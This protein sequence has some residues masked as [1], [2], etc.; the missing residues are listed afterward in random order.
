M[1]DMIVGAL[2]LAFFAMF[3]GGI[4]YDSNREREIAH[5]AFKVCIEAGHS[6][7]ECSA[8]LD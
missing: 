3:I 1:G 6:P 4:I 8:A 2:I 7:A 5:D